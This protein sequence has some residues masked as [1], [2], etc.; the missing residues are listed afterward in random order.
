[1]KEKKAATP[2]RLKVLSKLKTYLLLRSKAPLL[3]QSF[4]FSKTSP[5]FQFSKRNFFHCQVTLWCSRTQS[6]RVSVH[7]PLLT[8]LLSITILL[9]FHMIK[10]KNN[11]NSSKSNNNY[12]RF[13]N[14]CILSRIWEEEAAKRIW[15][16][17]RTLQTIVKEIFL[18][19]THKKPLETKLRLALLVWVY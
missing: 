3:R 11:T 8:V 10:T 12:C 15:S 1:M 17:K 14:S 18:I 2:Q 16:V 9:H 7:S 6:K 19:S 4:C 5:D 13:H